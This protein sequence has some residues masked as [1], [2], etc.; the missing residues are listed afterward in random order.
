MAEQFFGRAA[1]INVSGF[2]TD[3]AAL[4]QQFTEACPYDYLG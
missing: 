3:L 1:G 4:R 2:G